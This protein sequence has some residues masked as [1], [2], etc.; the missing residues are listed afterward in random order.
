MAHP[1]E[2]ITIAPTPRPELRPEAHRKSIMEIGKSILH[3]ALHPVQTASDT[4]EQLTIAAGAHEPQLL[5]GANEPKS[6]T[7]N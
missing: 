7:T 1:A 5:S 6:Q 4:L 2:R 3:I